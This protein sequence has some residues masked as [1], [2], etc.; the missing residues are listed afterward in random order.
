MKN[1]RSLRPDASFRR[2]LSLAKKQER[3]A[4]E[5]AMSSS[6]DNVVGGKFSF[7]GGGKKKKKRPRDDDEAA[8]EGSSSALAAAAPA[9][10]GEDAEAAEAAAA[11]ADALSSAAASSSSGPPPGSDS[12][13]AAQKRFDEVQ[14][15]RHMKKAAAGELKSHRDR[16]QGFNSYLA[17]MSE[18]YDLPKVSKGN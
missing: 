4:T 13:T 8:G 17:S 5:P 6:Y 16:V 14:L 11:H 15:Q 9:V 1:L 12:R 3:A 2:S 7:K 18:H 10:A